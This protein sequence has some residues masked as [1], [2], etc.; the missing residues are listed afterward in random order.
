[1]GTCQNA[2]RRSRGNHFRQRCVISDTTILICRTFSDVLLLHALLAGFEVS[3]H[4]N[5]SIDELGLPNFVQ[6]FTDLVF[7]DFLVT[8]TPFVSKVTFQYAPTSFSLEPSNHRA[9]ANDV[10]VAGSS[11]LGSSRTS[12]LETSTRYSPTCSP[13]RHS[14][15]PTLSRAKA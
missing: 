15:H 14:S 10:R 3:R 12:H 8:F 9:L 1:M 5:C 11:F 2:A 13:H 4:A 7:A 6:L